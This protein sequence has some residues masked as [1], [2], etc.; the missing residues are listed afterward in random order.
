[1]TVI[2]LF[3]HNTIII[4]KD[5]RRVRVKIGIMLLALLPMLIVS[6]VDGIGCSISGG[7]GGKD[8]GYGNHIEAGD[9]VGVSGHFSI[10]GDNLAGHCELKGHGPLSFHAIGKDGQGDSVTLDAKGFLNSG[11]ITAPIWIHGDGDTS[12]TGTQ[13][14]IATGSNIECTSKAVNRNG[15]EAT[16][17]AGVS[18]GSIDIDRGASASESTADAWQTINSA[19]GKNIELNAETSD[20]LKHNTADSIV[21]IHSGSLDHIKSEAYASQQNRNGPLDLYAIHGAFDLA[22]TANTPGSVNGDIICSKGFTTSETGLKA[23]YGVTI[24][25]G[26]VG[27]LFDW[28]TETTSNGK[29]NWKCIGKSNGWVIAVPLESPYAWQG[30]PGTAGDITVSASKVSSY[31]MALDGRKVKSDDYAQANGVSFTY[32]ASDITNWHPGGRWPGGNGFA[33][34]SEAGKP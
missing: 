29:S 8:Y 2:Y 26:S 18:K 28:G 6:G 33:V 3:K 27:G 21:M 31:S 19:N 34:S 20:K 11:G 16:V 13:S 4:I 12:I 9:G 25:E 15:L 14:L 24:E 30:T 17:L 23:L 7:N 1:M 10:N 22:N 32:T 5:I